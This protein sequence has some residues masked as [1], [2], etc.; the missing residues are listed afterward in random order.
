[1]APELPWIANTENIETYIHFHARYF[2]RAEGGFLVAM[3][4]GGLIKP[5]S[6]R[7]ENFQIGKFPALPVWKIYRLENFQLCRF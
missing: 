1:M 3:V 7:F 4:P 2:L 6:H 5:H